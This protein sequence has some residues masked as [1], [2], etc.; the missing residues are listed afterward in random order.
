MCFFQY[1]PKFE[2]KSQSL[3][4]ILYT[5]LSTNFQFSISNYFII[6]TIP[7]YSN[8][9]K[10]QK[11]YLKKGQS[12]PMTLAFNKNSWIYWLRTC[13]TEDVNALSAQTMTS[14]MLLLSYTPW[15]RKT[16]RHED[17]G[18]ALSTLMKSVNLIINPYP[19]TCL[20][21]VMKCS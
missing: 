14:Y 12:L 11:L 5:E 4:Y 9:K 17:E 16:L 18:Q 13:L 15:F 7:D 19:W 20:C 1:K 6:K 2:Y 21:T 8:P 3:F 10:M